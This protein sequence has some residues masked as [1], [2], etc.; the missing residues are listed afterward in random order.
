M[1]K[2]KAENDKR[3]QELKRSTLKLK[4]AKDRIAARERAETAVRVRE[5]MW[6]EKRLRKL[7]ERETRS[8]AVEARRLK[9]A[10]CVN[11]RKRVKKTQNVVRE[12]GTRLSDRKRAET[13]SGSSKEKSKFIPVSSFQFAACSVFKIVEDTGDAAVEAMEGPKFPPHAREGC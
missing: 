13:H 9:R 3:R 7:A 5:Q 10:R 8:R 11:K 1:L 6:Q 2:R 12:L 4:K